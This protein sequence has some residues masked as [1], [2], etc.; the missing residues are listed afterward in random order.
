MLSDLEQ[1][2]LAWD[3]DEAD[4]MMQTN[5]ILPG[6]CDVCIFL[7]SGDIVPGV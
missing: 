6:L 5:G 7:I 1:N 3:L 4:G 2:L